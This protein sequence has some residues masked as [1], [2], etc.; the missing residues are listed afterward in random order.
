MP[1]AKTKYKTVMLIDDNEIDNII[2]QKLIVSNN[3]AER[4]YIHTGSR[5][6]LEFLQNLNRSTE[7]M[8]Q[9]LPDIIFLDINMPGATGIEATNYIRDR[10]KDCFVIIFSADNSLKNIRAA[11]TNGANGFLAKP[12][13]LEKLQEI[14]RTALS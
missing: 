2:N 11:K 7:L 8:E 3:F 1:V 14:L 6:A 5:S 9:L 13:Q 4:L 10:N 12:F